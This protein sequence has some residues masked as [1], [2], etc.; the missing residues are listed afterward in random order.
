M[1]ISKNLYENIQGNLNEDDY[2][3]EL[4]DIKMQLKDNEDLVDIVRS[5]NS[6]NGAFEDLQ[7]WE[8]DEEFFDTFF[9][10]AMEAV[11]AACYGDYTF[12]DEYVKINAYGNLESTNY[13]QDE[14]EGY[15]DEIVDELIENWEEDYKDNLYLND[16]TKAM[17]ENYIANR[18]TEEP[19]NTEEV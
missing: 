3:S 8:N 13:I 17:I 10:N 6:Y 15:L 2:N 1:D 19:E 12:T 9:S 14:I 18:P 5:M 4:E 11:R 7:Y 16:E